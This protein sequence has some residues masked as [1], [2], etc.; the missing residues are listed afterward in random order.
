[1]DHPFIAWQ[2][3]ALILGLLSSGTMIFL[4]DKYPSS[5]VHP[6]TG[7][8]CIFMSV[9]IASIMRVG[10]HAW[11]ILLYPNDTGGPVPATLSRIANKKLGNDAGALE[12]YVPFYFW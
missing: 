3:T 11:Y 10:L 7:L 2:L 1:M 6:D 12:A 5:R 4:F 8:M 9:S